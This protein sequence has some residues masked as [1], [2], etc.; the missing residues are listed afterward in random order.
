MT[1]T[2]TGTMSVELGWLIDP[3][4]DIPCKAADGPARWLVRALCPFCRL[5]GH[6]VLCQD[7]ADDLREVMQAP[8]EACLC[9]RCR[10][11]AP[12]PEFITGLD[13]IGGDR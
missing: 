11:A 8:G 7:H 2:D 6:V 1:T 12:W 9:N 13:R 3:D 10:R 5:P 4:A